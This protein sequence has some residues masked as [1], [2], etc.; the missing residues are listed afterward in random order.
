LDV[1]PFRIGVTLAITG[2]VFYALCTLAWALV[3]ELFLCFTNDLFHGMDF[4][5]LIRAG[6]FSWTGF[7]VALVVPSA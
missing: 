7:L 3:P 5:R 1:N 2:G 4:S 6:S